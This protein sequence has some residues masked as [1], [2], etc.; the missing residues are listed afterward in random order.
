MNPW[1]STEFR[2]DRGVGGGRGRG[3]PS[4]AGCSPSI[5]A[6]P[7]TRD[8]PSGE[9]E[10]ARERGEREAR[11]KQ[12]IMS[13]WTSTES[14]RGRGVEEDGAVAHRLVQVASLAINPRPDCLYWLDWLD[15]TGWSS[16]SRQ[17]SESR[18]SSVHTSLDADGSPSGGRCFGCSKLSVYY[19]VVNC[20]CP[21]L[22]PVV[23]CLYI[24]PQVFRLYARL[25]GD[26]PRPLS[27]LEHV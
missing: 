21:R 25:A 3:P 26:D 23:K 17:S 2:R 15:L 13:D 10:R 6:T 1:I 16:Q 9:R 5:N 12:Q 18:Q 4:R 22:C 14:G 11:E 7:S 24:H 8:R 27:S 20:L 19:P